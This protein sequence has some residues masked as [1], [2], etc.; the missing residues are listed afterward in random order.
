M[1]NYCFGCMEHIEEGTEICPHCGYDQSLPAKEAYHL[2]PGT[3]LRA[4]YLIGKVIGYGGF[5][6]TYLGYDL[7]LGYKVAIKEYLPSEF[8]T[9]IPEQQTLSIYTGEA[10]KQ[11]EAGLRCFG[12]E[13]KRLAQFSNVPG[14]VKIFDVFHE[15]RTAYI[16][17]EF[18]DGE[19][20]ADRIKRE[21]KISPKEAVD[22]MGSVLTTL[23]DIHQTGMIHRDVSPGNIFV[24]K[25]GRVKLLD[26]GAARFASAYHTKSL[27]IILK[28]GYAPE[29]QYRSRGDQ[30]SWT[31]V[32]AAGATLYKM[33]TGITPQESVER[34]VKDEIKEPSKLGI[35]ISQNE[36]NALMNALNVEVSERT[37]T[38]GEFFTELCGGGDVERKKEAKR[39]RDEGRLPPWLIAF[40]C[41]IPLV[42]AGVIFMFMDHGTMAASDD[43]TTVPNLINKDEAS[44]KKILEDTELYMVVAGT[45]NVDFGESGLIQKSQPSS[46]SYIRKYETIEVYLSIN[47]TVFMPDVLYWNIENAYERMENAGLNTKIEYIETSDYAENI[48][49]GQE[50][51]EGD[52][53]SK[54]SLITLEVAKGSVLGTKKV[55]V[56]KVEGMNIEDAIKLL[57]ESGLYICITDESYSDVEKGIILEQY[58]EES[59]SEGST[60]NVK[61]S[62]GKE[63]VRMPDLFLKTKE[64]AVK[65]LEELGL[66]VKTEYEET[67]EYVE[68][69]VIGQKESA[70]TKLY[71]G[72]SVTIVLS[73]YKTGIV[74]NVVGLSEKDAKKKIEDAGFKM[75]VS[76]EK[77]PSADIKEGLIAKQSVVG[78]YQLGKVVTVNISDGV[79]EASVPN[80]SGMSISKAEN[81]IT[82]AGFVFDSESQYD[83]DVPEGNVISYSPTGKQPLGTTITC[84]VSLGP[85]KIDPPN[86]VGKD[87]SAAQQELS[88][89]GFSSSVSYQHSEDTAHGIVMS[90]SHTDK[91]VTLTV[92]KGTA[93]KYVSES[94]I[95]SYPSSQYSI[96]P[97][98]QYSYRH[99]GKET[100]Q[101][102]NS[103]LSGWTLDRREVVATY[104]E[105]SS[106]PSTG[107]TVQGDREV[108]REVSGGTGEYIT[109]YWRDI[110]GTVHAAGSGYASLDQC[111]D[112]IIDTYGDQVDDVYQESM[113][114]SF[115]RSVPSSINE[116]G[117]DWSLVSASYE[118]TVTEAVYYY[119]KWSDSWS[120]WSEWSSSDNAPSGEDI[121]VE[122]RTQTIYYVV[123]Q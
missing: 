98:T 7:M 109:Y 96:T 34:M 5:G 78:E 15:N 56:P 18:L 89:A 21:G 1:E 94:E 22:I 42:F 45:V 87:V 24:T 11:F 40:I 8:A 28:P 79:K 58:S 71:K 84:L 99:R 38:A 55:A 44:G 102:G 31:D 61:I 26:F 54:N 35:K 121:D 25:D 12:D 4:R 101:S 3:I 69:L 19:S 36:E 27:S 32:Y 68:D 57:R 59:V 114:K 14:V 30:G 65:A 86:V 85:E 77:V 122:T 17:M 117:T 93:G 113:T 76:A 23:N 52:P 10:E 92:S 112:I 83:E 119:W 82:S 62:L 46:G 53:L 110:N 67:N 41:C 29:E 104:T 80:V 88:N 91:D 50:F 116:N 106:S 66:V 74:P 2:A 107:T 95:N 120:E 103:S 90:Q 105:N 13:A 51:T 60:V 111:A 20:V 39:K 48:V 118:V 49:I 108:T 43:Y 72:D 6:V 75:V 73:K 16:I 33:L 70:G 81:E 64:E 123:G 47:E 37:Q 115:S 97:E 100:T 9:R 63:Y